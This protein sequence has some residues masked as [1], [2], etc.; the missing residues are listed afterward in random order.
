M[1]IEKGTPIGLKRKLDS[2]GRF[3]IPK[4]LRKDLNI[5]EGDKIEIFGY[6]NG[7]F[8]KKSGSV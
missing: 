3:V 2:L 4:E 1:K 5:K 8:I 7:I 6:E